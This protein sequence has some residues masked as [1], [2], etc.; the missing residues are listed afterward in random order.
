MRFG[1]LAKAA[2]FAAI[3]LTALPA[4]AEEMSPLIGA[5]VRVV[6]DRPGG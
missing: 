2:T 6:Q 3:V 5:I 1:R 4:R